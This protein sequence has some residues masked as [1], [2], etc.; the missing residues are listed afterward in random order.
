VQYSV[1]KS[2]RVEEH[3]EEGGG[4]LRQADFSRVDEELSFPRSGRRE[5]QHP[6]PP[7]ASGDFK[8]KVT[9]EGD[10]TAHKTLFGA[11]Q[12]NAKT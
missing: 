3:K 5:G 6:T 8:W 9:K 11:K 1:L 12:A 10:S 2:Q 4:G 7:H